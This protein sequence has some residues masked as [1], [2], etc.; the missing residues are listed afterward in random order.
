MSEKYL[1]WVP[2]DN[3]EVL[4]FLSHLI[5]IHKQVL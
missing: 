1:R 5:K 4:H 3:Y 2:H